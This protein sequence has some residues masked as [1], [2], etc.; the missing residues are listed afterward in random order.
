MLMADTMAIF[1]VILG[2]MLAFPALWLLSLG[3][4][5]RAVNEA[6]DS[7]SRGLVKPFLAGLPLTLLMI[8]IAASL[9][10]IPGA[11]GNIAAIG[12]TCLYMIFA[13]A[14]VA[15]L[16]TCI[17]R[18]LSS[19]VDG[20]RPWRATLRGGIVLELPF[21]LPL[22]GWFVILPAAIIIGCGATTVSLLRRA[23]VKSTAEVPLAAGSETA[24]FRA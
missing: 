19:P 14:G 9:K 6:A 10:K 12:A 7:C 4:W 22:L 8:I 21:L 5:P 2:F 13:H 1:F 20:D 3:L 24:G 18:R 15:G 11:L 17:G 23:F 16:A